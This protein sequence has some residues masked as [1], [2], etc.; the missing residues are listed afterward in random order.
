MEP[1]ASTFFGS[2]E[3]AMTNTFVLT[4]PDFTKPFAL[5]I[6]TCSTGI[7]VVLMQEGE[8]LAFLSK[9][10]S[11]RNI[12]PSTYEKEMK[13]IMEEIKKWKTYLQGHHYI[14]TDH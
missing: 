6:D 1:Q 7:R 4:L 12:G 10:L 5:E 9:L 2:L 13:A 11:E 14:K 3:K 8:P